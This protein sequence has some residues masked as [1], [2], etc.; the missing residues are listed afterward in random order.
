M[1]AFNGPSQRQL[2]IGELLRKALADVF[3]RTEIQD[4]DLS[5]I[6]LTVTEVSVSPDAKNAKAYILPLGGSNQDIV[7][8]ALN[9]HVK[10]IRGELSRKV[11]LKYMPQI[12]FEVDQSFDTSERIDSVLQS[13]QVARDLK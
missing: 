10:F 4:S 6:L 8:A 12:K 5:G 3:I 13:D 9:R 7:I 1:S 11:S 2:R